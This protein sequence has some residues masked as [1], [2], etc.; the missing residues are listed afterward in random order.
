[1][2]GFY[3]NQIGEGRSSWSLQAT[4]PRPRGRSFWRTL[5]G[6]DVWIKFKD[7]YDTK[8]SEKLPPGMETGVS[9]RR[10]FE[11]CFTWRLE[12][13]SNVSRVIN[14]HPLNIYLQCQQSDQLCDQLSFKYIFAMSAEWSI[15][16]NE[17]YCPSRSVCF[18]RWWSKDTV[19]MPFRIL[20]SLIKYVL[21]KQV[22]VFLLIVMMI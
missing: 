16:T 21:S 20:T 11:P 17:I 2:N 14:Y 3:V 7:N 15:I 12:N 9:V 1:M 6:L 4:F 18:C 10:S 8:I 5:I 19:F 22:C 13:I